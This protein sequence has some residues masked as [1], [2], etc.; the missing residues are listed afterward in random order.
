[1][2]QLYDTQAPNPPSRAIL[3]GVTLR[4]SMLHETEESLLELRQLTE[5]AGIKSGM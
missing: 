3:V 4:D 5:T 2:Q 1:M